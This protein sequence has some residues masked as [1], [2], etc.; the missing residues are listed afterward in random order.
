M[1]QEMKEAYQEVKEEDTIILEKMP[2]K[3]E[4][5]E[6]YCTRTYKKAQVS[7]Y[8]HMLLL[9]YIIYEDT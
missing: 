4:L 9:L 6:E 7:T 5:C 2:K 8:V 1:Y 3:R